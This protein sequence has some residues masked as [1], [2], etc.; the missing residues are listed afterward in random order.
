MLL[1]FF[2]TFKG[3]SS[4]DIQTKITLIGDQFIQSDCR[5]PYLLTTSAAT[6]LPKIL[7]SQS[8]FATALNPSGNAIETPTK[9]IY[10]K[11]SSGWTTSQPS[12]PIIDINF[13][14]YFVSATNLLA[15]TLNNLTIC[16]NILDTPSFLTALKA[17]NTMTVPK[18]TTSGFSSP[19]LTYNTTNLADCQTAM[20]TLFG[21]SYASIDEDTT[22]FTAVKRLLKAYIYTIH[23]YIAMTIEG[24]NNNDA[25]ITYRITTMITNANLGV[26]DATT[27]EYRTFRNEIQASHSAYS[28]NL[29]RIDKIDTKLKELKSDVK[30][31][32]QKMETHSNILNKNSVVYY[33]FLLLFIVASIVLLYAV[34]EAKEDRSKIIVG[35]VFGGSAL[36][37]AILYFLNMTYLKEGFTA[38][39]ATQTT[40]DAL[41]K[42]HLEDTLFLSEVRQH[43]H[44]INSVSQ[45]VNKE[46]DRYDTINHQLKLE[47]SGLHDVEADD[48]RNARVLQYRVYMLIQII[49]IVSLAIFIFLQ[50]GENIVVFGIALLL[51][52]FAI[53]LYIMN[54][55][56]LVHT[57]AKKLYWGQPSI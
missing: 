17:G 57:D 1:F 16:Y 56:N 54:T 40:L 21:T 51:V 23:V 47:K 36:S 44:T 5:T 33:V 6:N 14:N 55:E 27:G 28:N 4:T 49:I 50:T 35:V 43:S 31:E 11:T 18:Y 10:Y 39:T 41:I 25:P 8:T 32:R 20:T 29:D 37:L 30:E 24:N 12:S 13:T 52:L 53:Y 48:Y 2:N 46:I 38:Y 19:N 7:E 34:Q 42:I 15:T 26:R 9:I 22:N 3:M 45:I